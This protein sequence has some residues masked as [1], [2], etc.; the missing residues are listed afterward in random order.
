MTFVLASSKKLFESHTLL[1]INFG[2]LLNDISLFPLLIATTTQKCQKLITRS[3]KQ[4]HTL[5]VSWLAAW[6]AMNYP[7]RS[8][9]RSNA[10]DDR[11]RSLQLVR[12][13]DELKSFISVTIQVQER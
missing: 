1:I 13:D 9:I 11:D 4:K 3:L 6:V 10:D 12:S 2:D 5:I 7:P 8:V